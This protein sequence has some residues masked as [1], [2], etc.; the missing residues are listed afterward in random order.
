MRSVTSSVSV[1]AA[2]IRERLLEN[3]PHFLGK[4]GFKLFDGSVADGL[5]FVGDV[6]CSIRVPTVALSL[7]SWVVI[8]A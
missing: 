4:G 8:V 3:S 2:T 5:W 1:W 7:V 6:T